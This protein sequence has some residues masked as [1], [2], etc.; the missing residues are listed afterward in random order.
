MPQTGPSSRRHESPQIDRRRV[1]R[2]SAAENIGKA[3]DDAWDQIAPSVSGRPSAIEAARLK[4]AN[5][6]LSLAK[7]GALDAERLTEEALKIMSADPTHL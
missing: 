2:S 3:F 5:V 4:L 7:N 6:V 1:L